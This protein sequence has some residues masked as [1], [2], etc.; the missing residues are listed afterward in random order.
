MLNLAYLIVWE[1]YV[2]AHIAAYQSNPSVLRK[3]VAYAIDSN[4][5]IVNL[6]SLLLACHLHFG[7]EYD[8]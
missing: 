7:K 4:P 1:A 3:S 8:L 2:I 5:R 6:E